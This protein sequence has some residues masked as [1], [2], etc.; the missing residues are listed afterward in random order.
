MYHKATSSHFK[1]E[2]RAVVVPESKPK[3]RHAFREHI[4]DVLE[5]PIYAIQMPPNSYQIGGW[6]EGLRV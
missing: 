1:A 5:D 2:V 4:F 3:D 6:V